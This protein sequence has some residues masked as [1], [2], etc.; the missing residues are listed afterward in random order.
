MS[1]ITLFETTTC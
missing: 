1:K